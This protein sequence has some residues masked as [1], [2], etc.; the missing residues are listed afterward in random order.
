[1]RLQG[2]TESRAGQVILMPVGPHELFGQDL[3]RAHRFKPLVLSGYG[4]T[5]S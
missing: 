5:S 4:H 2:T 3:T 1:M